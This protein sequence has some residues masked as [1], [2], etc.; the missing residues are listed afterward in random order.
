MQSESIDLIYLDPPFNSNRNYNFLYSQATGLPLPEEAEAFCDAWKL[1]AI[2]EETIRKMG[3]EMLQGGVNE[4]FISFW[5]NWILALRN[6]NSKLL[7]YMVFMTERLVEMRRLL[8]STGSIY[9]HCDP[10][11][12]HY[13]KIIMDGIFGYENFRNEI[14]WHYKTY[15]GRINSRKNFPEKHDIIFCYS[16]SKINYFNGIEYSTNYQE[17]VDFKRWNKY[18]KNGNKIY[19]GSHPKTDSRFLAYRN[20][21]IADNNREPKNGELIYEC[22]GDLVC[23]VWYIKAVDPKSKEKLGY[24]TQKPLALLDRIIKASCPENGVILDPFCG[25]GTTVISAQTNNRNWIGID[26]C[27]LAVNSMESRLQNLFPL[28]KKGRDYRVDGLPTT[29]QQAITLAN[30]GNSTKNEGRYQF[31]YWAIE[32]IGGFASTKKSGDGG[33]DGSI[34]FYKDIEGKG[35]GKMIISVKSDKDLKISYIRDLVGTLSNDKTAEMAGLVCIDEPTEGMKAEA[36]KA[37]FYEVDFG[38][39]GKQSF[40]KVQILTIKD[41]IENNKKFQTPFKVQKKIAERV[42]IKKNTNQENVYSTL[43]QN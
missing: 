15:Y 8:K 28:L 16:K 26:I 4:E 39:M 12:S 30:S 33:V 14:V 29:V 24:P 35:L 36:L 34:Y 20:K 38:M 2:K 42:D 19:E 13:I 43:F 32:K 3:E 31:Q 23:D 17:T 21:W 22:N 9:L 27:M 1:D 6:T 11:A 40:Q 37:G 25:C 10:T 7:A 18:Y 41:I 5:E